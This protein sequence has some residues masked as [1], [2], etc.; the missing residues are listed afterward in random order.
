MVP[1]S[2]APGTM[3]LLRTG[4][5]PHLTPLRIG[6]GAVR[7]GF[8]EV[9]QVLSNERGEFSLEVAVPAWARRDLIHRFIVFDFYFVPIALSP[10]FHVTDAEGLVA[11]AGELSRDRS[12]CAALRTDDGLSYGLAGDLSAFRTGSRVLV[13][14]RI[15]GS[16]ACAQGITLEAV[17]VRPAPAP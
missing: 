2:G 3:V 1:L 8:E 5:M 11:R 14:G 7:F 15:R 9:G 16:P 6:V 4:G 10:V 12:G 13:E 17:R